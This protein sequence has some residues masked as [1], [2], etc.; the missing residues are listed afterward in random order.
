MNQTEVATAVLRTGGWDYSSKQTIAALVTWFR[1]EGGAGPQWG[2][3]GNLDAYNPLNTTLK[4][5]GSIDEPGN[6][7]PCQSYTSW[8]QGIQATVLTLQEN[9]RGYS[10]IRNVL[11]TGGDCA[12][13]SAA[14][15][16]SA[17][18]TS[19]FAHLCGSTNVPPPPTGPPPSSVKSGGWVIGTVVWGG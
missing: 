12:A 18:G 3:P 4:M 8:E 7:P 5:P 15:A 9:W 11:N 6:N 1:A 16:A 2:I 14:V 10:G 19:G 17:W 13:L